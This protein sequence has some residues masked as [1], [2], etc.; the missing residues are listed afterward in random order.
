MFGAPNDEEY[1]ETSYAP[2]SRAH[3]RGCDV[4][5]AKSNIRI[6]HFARIEEHYLT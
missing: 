1:I 6:T 5:I 3:C 2:S 4:N